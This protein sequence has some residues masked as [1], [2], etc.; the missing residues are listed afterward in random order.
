MVQNPCFLEVV[1]LLSA[2]VVSM[3]QQESEDILTSSS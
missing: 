2:V 3:R 1:F